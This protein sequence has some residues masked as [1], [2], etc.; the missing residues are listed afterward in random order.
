MGKIFQVTAKF[1]AKYPNAV[2]LI[3]G[4]TVALGGEELVHNIKGTVKGPPRVRKVRPATQS[5]LKI[6]FEQGN[7]YIEEVEGPKTFKG[8]EEE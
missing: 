5:D 2:T 7:T 3:D 8:K 1:K 6:L 4:V